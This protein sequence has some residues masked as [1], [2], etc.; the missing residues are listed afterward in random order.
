M[1]KLLPFLAIIAIVLV[2]CHTNTATDPNANSTT[3]KYSDTLGLSQFQ[4]WKAQ[5][6]LTPVSQ[7]PGNIQGG[8]VTKT[9]VYYVPTTSKRS[10][11]RRSYSSGS[12]NSVSS[13]TAMRKKGWSKAAKGAAIGAGGGAILGAIINKRNPLVG[14]I[15]GGVLGG[16]LGYGIGRSKDKADG[17]Y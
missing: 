10:T 3:G 5:N 4:A 6:E 2:A 13:N 9:I 8:K 11:V 16:G 15:I 14:G 12:Y 7:Y 17:R 1:K